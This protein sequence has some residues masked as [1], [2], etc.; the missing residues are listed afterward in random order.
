MIM[1]GRRTLA[2]VVA[3]VLGFAG[4]AFV[5]TP[6]ANAAQTVAFYC[7]GNGTGI[8]GFGGLAPDP[9][10]VQPN[11]SVVAS[12][13][14][15]APIELSYLGQA[16]VLSNVNFG[17]ATIDGPGVWVPLPSTPPSNGAI[18]NGGK[19]R[20]LD[21]SYW[22]PGQGGGGFLPTLAFVTV[23]SAGVS[24]VSLSVS[25][26]T[27]LGSVN[28]TNTVPV[29]ELT[30][31]GI[32]ATAGL[33][34]SPAYKV[35]Q[36][37]ATPAAAGAASVALVQVRDE[38]GANVAITNASQVTLTAPT[39][40]WANPANVTAVVANTAADCNAD[41]TFRA[42]GTTNAADAYNLQGPTEACL[43]YSS[44][45]AAGP[46]AWINVTPPANFAGSA[47]IG[48]AVTS[49]VRTYTGSITFVVS[50][51]LAANWTVAFDKQ[52]YAP[53]ELAELDICATDLNGRPVPDGLNPV[54]PLT[55]ALAGG[56]FNADLVDAVT[57]NPT[58]DASTLFAN[59]VNTY[60]GCATGRVFMPGT[61][62]TVNAS[63]ISGDPVTTA[64]GTSM[65]ANSAADTRKATTAVVRSS[66]PTPA[67]I[68]IVGER[69]AGDGANMVFVE[70]TTTGLVGKTVTPHFRFP[71]QTGFTAGTGTRTVDPQGN[72]DWS[73]KTGKQIAVQFRGE[74]VVS[75]TV[76]IAAK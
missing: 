21:A 64:P 3:A 24:T 42:A 41:G 53:G 7:A 12:P 35:V 67:T 51:P 30:V 38:T 20:T 9:T 55:R 62:M 44:G 22:G 8:N 6:T 58:A 50:S 15:T 29:G 49:G 68:M 17:Q 74:G 47:T 13:T 60:N 48:I 14:A 37:N 57:G 16:A 33:V 39:T 71:G 66:T 63:V 65:W 25:T 61:P 10:T 31:T 32:G 40:A 27:T 45:I 54:G 5:A 2:A 23:P 26:A 72:F 34:I 69:G 19:T 52:T 4:L 75:N 1:S 11:C 43:A 46:G 70:G 56:A 59:G 18:T 73:R 28:A 36:S 76:I